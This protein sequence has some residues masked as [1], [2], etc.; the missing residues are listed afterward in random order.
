MNTQRKILDIKMVLSWTWALCNI[1]HWNHPLYVSSRGRRV[2]EYFSRTKRLQRFLPSIT[3]HRTGLGLDGG[4]LVGLLL[5]ETPGERCDNPSAKWINS[6]KLLSGLFR[7]E[8]RGCGELQWR[9]EREEG[10]LLYISKP[11]KFVPKHR[12]SDL[13]IKGLY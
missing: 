13:Q 10:V 2:R 9:P 12:I 5:A 11:F 3:W 8:V 1:H 7:V 6:W 4:S